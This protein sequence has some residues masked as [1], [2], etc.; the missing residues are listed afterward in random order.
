MA[1]SVKYTRNKRRVILEGKD[2][3]LTLIGM[4]RS[5]FVFKVPSDNKALKVFFPEF[6]AI[7][8]EE[9]EIYRMLKGIPQFPE[10]HESGD[11]YLVIDYIEGLTLFDCL[12]QGIPI[13]PEKIQE[14]DRVLMLAKK[15]GLNPSDI[16]LRNI[17]FTSKGEIKM[18][19]VARFRQTKDCLQ[20]R[21]LKRAFHWF[22]F[23]PFCPK[24]IP[25]HVLNMI[26]AV[27]KKRLIPSPH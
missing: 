26:A 19:D 16:H 20:W 11:N 2:E 6:K 25:A 21:D 9:A 24:K 5:A 7:A 3:S 22:Y 10:L 8:Q 23:K 18:I 1:E 13:D 12:T 4:G 27:Y 17:L 15:R 14:V